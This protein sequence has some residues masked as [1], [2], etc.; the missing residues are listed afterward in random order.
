MYV[1]AVALRERLLD[2]DL[3][4]MREDAMVVIGHRVPKSI[5]DKVARYMV[6]LIDAIQND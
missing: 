6:K 2:I 4:Q 3:Q 5:E 1:E